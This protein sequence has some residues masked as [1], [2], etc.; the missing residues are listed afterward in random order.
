MK[1]FLVLATLTLAMSLF[2]SSC[3]D[4]DETTGPSDVTLGEMSA[5]VGGSE[6][7]AGN[8]YYYNATDHVSGIYTPEPLTNPTKNTSISVK[9]AQI[10]GEP[11][12]GTH[13]AICYYQES[14]GFPPNS[15]VS[16]WNATNGSCEVTEVTDEYVKGTFS[17]TG[18]NEDDNS[19]KSVSGKFYTPRQ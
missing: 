14:E 8:A 10:G 7:K 6:W 4:E 19:T 18:T 1:K 9:L 2:M 11:T 16:T 13:T 15:T 5:T 3:A 17:F 12:V